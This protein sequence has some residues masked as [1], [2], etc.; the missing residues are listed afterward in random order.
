MTYATR[1]DIETLYG[2]DELRFALNLAREAVLAAGDI[3]RVDRALAET[4]SQIDAY[5]GV[6][7]TLPIAPVPDVL[8]AFAVDM[9]VYRLALRVGRPRDELRKRYDDAVAYLRA[10][11]KGDAN[12]PGVATGTAGAGGEAA[13]GSSGDV[14]FTGRP[15]LFDRDSE[16]MS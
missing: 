2:G 4:S 1:A 7:Y 8:R 14:R 12:L 3:E 13:Q 9:T 15:R 10:V 16:V 11:A 5:L 6:R